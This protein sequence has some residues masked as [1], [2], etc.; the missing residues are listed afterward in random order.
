[1]LCFAYDGSINGDW[2]S[3]YAIH[4]AAHHGS[5]TLRLIHISDGT[6]APGDLRERIAHL[7]ERCAGQGVVLQDEVRPRRGEVYTD[8]LALLPPGDETLVICGAR[9]RASNLGFLAGTVSER[10]LE[11]RG[12]RTMAVRVMNPGLLGVP[13]RFLLPLAGTPEG[14]ATSLPFLRLFAPE[15]ETIH[16]LMVKEVRRARFRHLT[17]AKGLAL[18]EPA[19]AY[20]H[21]V[22]QEL[23]ARLPLPAGA[24]DDT[25]VLS[26]DAPKEILIVAN[27]IRSRLILLGASQRNLPDKFFFGNPIEQVLRNAPCDVAIVSGAA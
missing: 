21:S 18:L 3:H 23:R 25:V 12:I 22:E 24:V 26:D 9:A 5:R 11:A 15:I 16:I 14:L 13:R 19:R 2:V 1:M 8:L 27:R 20:L 17:A 6:L 4:L 10:L 7:R